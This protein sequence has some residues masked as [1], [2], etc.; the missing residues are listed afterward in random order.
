V[1]AAA[2]STASSEGGVLGAI[3]AQVASEVANCNTSPAKKFGFIGACCNWFL[4]FSA[5][6]DS[7][8]NGPQVISLPMTFAMLMYSVLFGRWAAFDVSPKNYVLAGSHLFNIAAQCNQ[9]RRALSYKL[10]TQ[11][12]AKAEISALGTKAAGG[13]TVAALFTLAAPTLKTSMPEGTWLASAVGPFT[14]HP[15]PPVTKLFLSAASLTDLHRPTDQISLTQY[16]ALTVTGLIF[17]QYGLLVTPINYPLTAVNILL[18]GS[19]AWH[20]GRKIKADFL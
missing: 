15:W 6:Y 13:L 2:A 16:A 8:R 1:A 20:L 19:S 9:L 11:P 4:G 14:I 10:E 3:L 18:F 17:S 12:G 7:L 5:V